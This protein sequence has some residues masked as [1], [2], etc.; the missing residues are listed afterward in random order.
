MSI[1]APTAIDN[2]GSAVIER[3]LELDPRQYVVADS[4][5]QLSTEEVVT[6]YEVNRT[7]E[8]IN[9]GRYQRIGLQFPDELLTYSAM[10][11]DE[12]QRKV[13]DRQCQIFILAD[14][15]YGSCCV[16]EVAAQHYSA[17]LIVHYG[18]TCLSL[19]SRIPVF[20]VFGREPVDIADCVKKTEQHIGE[21]KNILLAYDVPYTHVASEVVAELRK[22]EGIGKV[23]CSEIDVADKPYDVPE[24]K[25][26]TTFCGKV[27]RD[28]TNEILPGRSWLLPEGMSISDFTILYLGSESLTLTNLLLTQRCE[29]IFSYDPLTKVL[30]EETQQANRHLRRRY[31]MVQQ[32]RDADVVGIVVGTLAVTRYK[33]VIETLKRMLRQIH[34]KFYVFVVGKLNVAK[35][36]N[37]AEIDVF[38]LVACPENSLVDSREYY[39]SIVTPYEMLL[40]VSKSLEWT[41]DYI[42]D[43]RLFLETADESSVV[44]AEQEDEDGDKPHFSLITGQLKLNKK[45]N[46]PADSEAQQLVAGMGDLVLRNKNTEIARYMGSAGAEHLMGRSF[47]GLGHDDDDDDRKQD[48][49]EPMLAVEGKSGIARGYDHEPR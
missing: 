48:D 13:T 1:T 12:L 39:R 42:T 38:V 18:R 3:E 44:E 8:V 36:A 2:D 11:S 46:N 40:A 24:D 30:R 17:D 35:L 43:F 10:V 23:V 9:D 32:A 41:G 6:I 31:V 20:Y 25:C 21:G 27:G 47:R 22:I 33:A 28:P 34:R 4:K 19:T 45:Y 16:D 37:F 5:R 15:S 14:T 26:Q 29:S 49:G 7:A